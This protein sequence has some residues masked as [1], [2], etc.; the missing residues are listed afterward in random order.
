MKSNQQKGFTIIELL[1]VVAIIAL[2][3]TMV[4][5]RLELSRAMARDTVRLGDMD[6]I[7][8]ALKVYD[9][10]YLAYPSSVNCDGGGGNICH[11]TSSVPDWIPALAGYLGKAIRDPLQDQDPDFRY[12]YQTFYPEPGYCENGTWESCIQDQAIYPKDLESNDIPETPFLLCFRLE[13]D[14]TPREI[15]KKV[16]ANN[17]YCFGDW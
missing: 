12:S 15:A 5:I 4:V 14:T 9:A 1:I 11:S 16:L 3:A 7:Y 2:L 10:G 8:K 6:A 13:T 17:T